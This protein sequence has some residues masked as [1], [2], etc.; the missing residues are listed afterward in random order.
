MKRIPTWLIVA[1]VGVGAGSSESAASGFMV[2][3][4]SAASLATVF[5]G[6]ASR[7]DE[8]ATVFNNPAGMSWLE[9]TQTQIG[10]TGVFPSIN[11]EGVATVY[12]ING[13]GSPLPADNSRNNGQFS[14]VPHAYAVFDLHERLKAGIAIT[15]PFG[16]TI[17][18]SEDW[19]GRYVNIKTAAL[20]IDINPNVSYKLTDRLAI[21]GG[22]SLQYLSLDL[23]SRI[24]QFVI[25]QDPTAPDGGFLL[26]VDNW[27]WGFNL[28]LLAEPWDGTKL[29]VTYRSGIDHRMEGTLTF[30]PTTHP[31]VGM[32]SGAYTDI[33]V[34]AST[35][36]SFT[37]QLSENFSLSADVQF[38]QWNTFKQVAVYSDNPPVV[39]HEEYRDTWMFSV[40]GVYRLNPVWTLRAGFGF[41]Q[42]PVVDAFRDTGVPD[43]DRYMVG[44]G[45]GYQ[46]TPMV[47]LD[48]GYARYIAAGHATMN[49][50]VNRIEPITGAVILN[51]R[52]D[53][54][55]DYLSISL[56]TAL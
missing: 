18:Y 42:S 9:G 16:N 20:S 45:F 39:F 53:N 13:V 14:F 22:V 11:F 35:T 50:S 8:V 56:R 30:D 12:D 38:T 41:D 24:P 26:D 28:G 37:Q 49:E 10:G 25:F 7:A 36:G 34:P 27:G 55:I 40:G 44:F 21:A 48:V 47:A 32:T 31:L 15:V 19:S 43:K 3:E 29:G 2:R 51:G 33:S 4:N 46:I 23:S 5:A 1:G 52:Y 54:H 6:N 17:D